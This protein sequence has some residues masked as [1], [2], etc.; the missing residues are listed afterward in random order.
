MSTVLLWLGLVALVANAFTPEQSYHEQGG[1][2]VNEDDEGLLKPETICIMTRDNICLSTDVYKPESGSSFSTVYAKTPYGKGSLS[3]TASTYNKLG[4]V[5]LAQDCRGRHG[6]NGSY[7]FW[8][9]SGNDTIDTIEWLMAQSWSDGYL[10]VT[11]TSADALAQYAD[12]PGVS[13]GGGGTNGFNKYNEILN[14]IKFGTFLY[15]NTPMSP[16]RFC[17]DILP[18]TKT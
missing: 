4:Y 3:G 5:V 1:I 7:S 14:H 12:I 15:Q 6:S 2:I 9:T 11:G 16:Y 13:Q 8:R 17:E 18:E 10:G